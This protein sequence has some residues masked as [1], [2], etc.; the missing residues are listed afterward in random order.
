MEKKGRASQIGWTTME[1]EGVTGEEKDNSE[2]G[3]GNV[4]EES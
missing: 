1:E 2:G 3:G 4:R